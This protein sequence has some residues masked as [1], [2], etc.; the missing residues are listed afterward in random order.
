MPA[1]EEKKNNHAHIEK[2][3][4]RSTQKNELNKVELPTAMLTDTITLCWE[5]FRNVICAGI[6]FSLWLLSC[7]FSSSDCIM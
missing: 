1:L 3:T 6:V 5:V 2:G 4:I 7:V